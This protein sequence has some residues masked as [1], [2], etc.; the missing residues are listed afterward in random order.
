MYFVRINCWIAK[1]FE[2]VIPHLVD[3]ICSIPIFCLVNEI[4]NS[5]F[6]R[7]LEK[8]KQIAALGKSMSALIRE[9]IEKFLG[10][11]NRY[12]GFMKE[13]QRYLRKTETN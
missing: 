8:I 4:D 9:Q 10:E 6:R 2:R 11:E 3:K 5:S 12:T 7:N 1:F 13:L